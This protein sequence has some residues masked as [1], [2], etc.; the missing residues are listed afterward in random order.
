M[1]PN[2]LIHADVY[3]LNGSILYY[4]AVI[5]QYYTYSDNRQNKVRGIFFLLLSLICLY[6]FMFGIKEFLKLFVTL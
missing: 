6:N 1:E 3:F 5:F 4:K 2:R